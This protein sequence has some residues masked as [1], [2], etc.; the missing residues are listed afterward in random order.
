MRDHTAF[1]S[2][3][4]VIYCF[5]TFYDPQDEQCQRITDVQTK[6][7]P[8]TSLENN[9]DVLPFEYASGSVHSSRDR[10]FAYP[11]TAL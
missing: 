2:F 4:F 3:E 10:A 9:Q 6:A 8:G 1:Q 5:L 11:E 7:L